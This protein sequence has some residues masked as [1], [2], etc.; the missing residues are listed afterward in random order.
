[1]KTI[2]LFFAL[3]CLTTVS[4]NDND[5]KAI[6]VPAAMNPNEAIDGNWS[7]VNVNGGIAGTSDDYPEGLIVW[8][9]N[10]ANQTV[11]VQNGNTDPISQDILPSGEYDYS[12][13]SNEATPELCLMNIKVGGVN[14]GC[15]NIGSSIFTMSQIESDGFLIKLTR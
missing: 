5:D 14:L 12:F 9:F 4:C 8:K 7:L 15:F 3:L 2:K 13:V 6:A 11:V 1:M 10:S